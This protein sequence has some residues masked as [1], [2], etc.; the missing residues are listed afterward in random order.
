VLL[1]TVT[2]ALVEPRD[3][4]T[5]KMA[6]KLPISIRNLIG[7]WMGNQIT[8][9]LITIPGY[10]PSAFIVTYCINPKCLN[11]DDPLNASADIC[12]NCGSELLLQ[13]RYRVKRLL[14]KGGFGKTFEAEDLFCGSSG[15]S[16]KIKVLKVLLSNSL[17][18]VEL[19]QREAD[20]LS[21]LSHRGI[22]KVDFDAYFTILPPYAIDP[23]HC[24]VM[25]FIEGQNL[26]EWLEGQGSQ[27]ITQEQALEWLKQLAE[28]LHELHQQQ[29][30]HRD[31]KPSNIMLTPEEQLVLIDFG[32]V[33]EL[34][35]TYYAK[36]GGGLEGITSLIS[37]G[38]TPPEQFKG[39]AVPQS[40]FYALGR[41]F[42]YLLTG[43]HPTTFEE[44]S[45]EKLL[46]RENCPQISP[47]L[48]NFIDVLMEPLVLGRP[49]NTQE[50]LQQLSQIELAIK[51]G[52]PETAHNFLAETPPIGANTLVVGQA[53]QGLQVGRNAAV[54]RVK[55]IRVMATLPVLFLLGLMGGLSFTN[56]HMTA[57]IL[58]DR[59][60][61]SYKAGQPRLAHFY[62]GL[63]LLYKSNLVTTHYNQGV[64]YEQ[65]QDFSD[66]CAKYQTVIAL[67]DRNPEVAEKASKKIDKLKCT[68][69][70]ANTI[71]AR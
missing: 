29:Y 53:S 45:N 28:I 33:R 69:N 62:Y 23:L 68:G 24:L 1:V 32:T 55:T 31:I 34:S 15:Q 30:F 37:Y 14:G 6:I 12:C 70:I 50:F 71:V 27:P 40:D 51:H 59:G 11:P 25:E 10:D 61:E 56:R 43:K 67:G 42:V 39:K 63:A 9:R 20:V 60:Y 52:M 49:K 48:A 13:E 66:A 46:W 58:N 7:I 5:G 57:I 35:S 64:L 21:R 19:F 36:V 38:Y 44:D 41:T 2:N 3:R 47:H 16:G 26:E 18:A 8:G 22:P 17:K 54:T 4:L 65:S